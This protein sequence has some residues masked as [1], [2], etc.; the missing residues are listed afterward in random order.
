MKL[1]A[2]ESDWSGEGK[3]AGSVVAM[4]RPIDRQ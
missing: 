2:K 1:L 4:Y 3:M